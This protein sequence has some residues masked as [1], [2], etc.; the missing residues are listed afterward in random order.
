[1]QDKIRPYELFKYLDKKWKHILYYSSEVWAISQEPVFDGDMLQNDM[2]DLFIY[3][4]A[5]NLT[6]IFNFVIDWWHFPY[7]PYVTFSRSDY[8]YL[9]KK[10]DD[11]LIEIDNIS[12]HYNSLQESLGSSQRIKLK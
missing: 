8:E 3:H 9:E 10:K 12:K 4:E 5:I 7:S 2:E 1:M 6:S 11:I